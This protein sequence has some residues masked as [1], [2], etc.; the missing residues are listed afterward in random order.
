MAL[1]TCE[2]Y[3]DLQNLLS[4][5]SVG[6]Q[7]LLSE[8]IIIDMPRIKCKY[9]TEWAGYLSWVSLKLINSKS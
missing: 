4:I 7:I 6:V 1:S 8:E 2:L 9:H 3:C 5:W